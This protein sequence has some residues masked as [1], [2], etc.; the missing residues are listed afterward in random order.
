MSAEVFDSRRRSHVAVTLLVAPEAER[1]LEGPV[2]EF[3]HVL[4]LE[5]QSGQRRRVVEQR[6][7]FLRTTG[8]L[9]AVGPGQGAATAG[10]MLL[11]LLLLRLRSPGLGY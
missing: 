10:L 5:R 4:P 3:A 1:R 6:V 11:L 7:W 9:H 2:A 8:V